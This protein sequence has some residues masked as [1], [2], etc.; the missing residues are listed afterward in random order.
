MCSVWLRRFQK[1]RSLDP[2]ALPA[3][4]RGE[5]A[6]SSAPVRGSVPLYIPPF[7]QK[8]KKKH[9][10]SS[11]AGGLHH[12]PQT[13]DEH[14]RQQHTLARSRT[15]K[16]YPG[17]FKKKEEKIE[18]KGRGGGGE[19]SEWRGVKKKKM[20]AKLYWSQKKKQLSSRR[21]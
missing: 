18:K 5:R 16:Q 15:P 7:L 17:E 2:G 10:A 21:L 20:D 8:K 14:K 11:R 3:V 6:A 12:V 13:A 9:Q 4:S 1:S 19:C